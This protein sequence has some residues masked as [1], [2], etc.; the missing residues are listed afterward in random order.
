MKQ[1]VL[2]IVLLIMTFC[3]WGW[4]Y[5]T[6]PLIEEIDQAL[7]KLQASRETSQKTATYIVLVENKWAKYLYR[8]WR[9]PNRFVLLTPWDIKRGYDRKK[10]T[11]SCQKDIYWIGEN[12]P[13][14]QLLKWG[15]WEQTEES[16]ITSSS[17][18]TLYQ[19]K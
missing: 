17:G 15:A 10:K 1:F 3:F 13:P 7:I 2:S 16:L 19:K 14:K 4:I 6:P 9:D 11:F 12:A 8:F 5:N 18:V